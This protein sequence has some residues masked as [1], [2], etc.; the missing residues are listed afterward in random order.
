MK[1]TWEEEEPGAGSQNAESKMQSRGQESAV[2]GQGLDLQLSIE[3]H[4]LQL[5]LDLQTGLHIKAT[6]KADLTVL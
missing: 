1:A 2:R 5:A 6:L 4:V 3:D